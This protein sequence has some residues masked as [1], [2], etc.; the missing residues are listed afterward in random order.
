MKQA[1]AVLISLLILNTALSISPLVSARDTF[2][3][4]L[5]LLQDEIFL[6]ILIGLMTLL[7]RVSLS[8]G[9]L[10]DYAK[11]IAVIFAL[12]SGFI[13]YTTPGYMQVLK[14]FQAIIFLALIAILFFFLAVTGYGGRSK[15]FIASACAGVTGYVLITL[16]GFLG[17]PGTLLI[18]MSL[19][20][21]IL[22]IAGFGS[23]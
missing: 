16:G 14:A 5:T 22:G 17:F 7:L 3:S 11:P 4:I 8:R 6:I 15:Y 2:R 13:F 12:I 20:S 18:I 21:L 9:P 23:D 1:T 10:E 19:I